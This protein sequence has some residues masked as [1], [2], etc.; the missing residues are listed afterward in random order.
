MI[1]IWLR[2]MRL[3]MRRY[4]FRAFFTTYRPRRAGVGHGLRKNP[5]G[6]CH[7]WGTSAMYLVRQLQ[8]E[9]G[10]AVEAGMLL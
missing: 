5:F 9:R 1:Y 3:T 6:R 10:I 7:G 2:W 8:L 4:G